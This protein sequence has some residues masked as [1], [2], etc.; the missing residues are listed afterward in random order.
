[1]SKPAL[2]GGAVKY[3]E[4]IRKDSTECQVDTLRYDGAFWNEVLLT[5][6]R[7]AKF[8]IWVL[9]LQLQH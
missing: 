6:A 9:R 4:V 1:M 5:E 7:C 8:L 2:G 3:A